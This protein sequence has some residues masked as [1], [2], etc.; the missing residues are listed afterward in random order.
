MSNQLSFAYKRIIEDKGAHYRLPA[1]LLHEGAGGYV[2]LTILGVLYFDYAFKFW[3]V[4]LRAAHISTRKELDYAICLLLK[5][6][7][8][9]EFRKLKG[10]QV[11]KCTDEVI[12]TA[13]A[14][15]QK[16]PMLD[17]VLKLVR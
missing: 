10:T 8:D 1:G 15:I 12:A 2:S 4:N 3:G 9:A 11:G 7:S 6:A 13:S 16:T 5:A 17:R 14:F